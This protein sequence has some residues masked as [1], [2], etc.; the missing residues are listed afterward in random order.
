MLVAKLSILLQLMHVFAPARDRA[1]YYV[2]QGMIWFNIL[3]Y[4]TT[5]FIVIFQCNPRAKFWNPTLP[6]HCL[7]IVTINIVTAAINVLSDVVLLLLP[8]TCIWQLQMKNRTKIALSAVFAT[9]TL[10]VQDDFNCG[11][12]ALIYYSACIASIMR[13][14]TGIHMVGEQDITWAI[15]DEGLW[16]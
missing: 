1:T 15:M 5:M 11:G 12:P 16:T 8:V 3:F 14:V 10:Y 4:L 7:N 6:G 2:C 13:L 9:G